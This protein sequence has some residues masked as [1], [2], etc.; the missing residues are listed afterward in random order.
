MWKKINVINTET[1]S[2]SVL[3]TKDATGFLTIMIIVRVTR[4]DVSTNSIPYDDT[5]SPYRRIETR[6]VV[7]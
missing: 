3:D 6:R 4:V 1:T 2:R 5:S 7:A